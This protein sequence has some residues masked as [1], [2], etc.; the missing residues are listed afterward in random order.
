MIKKII[1]DFLANTAQKLVRFCVHKGCMTQ[2]DVIEKLST[3]V[4]VPTKH[5]VIKFFCPGEIPIWRANTFFDLEPETLAWV[6]S[7]EADTVFFDIGA[8]VG[9]Y[10]L[11]AG[12]KG[13]EVLSFEPYSAN[14]YILNKNIY[15]N[16]LD[17][18]ITALSAAVSDKFQFSK[19][20]MQNMQFGS[21]ENT[22]G[23]AVDWKEEKFIPKFQQGIM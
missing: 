2:D 8:N 13:H 15:I 17:H 18:R 16:N 19:F 21:A 9:L 5:G 23:K 4:D 1:K 3:Y 11:Y 20:Y 12:M 14:Q 22:T 7:F 6:D 10:S